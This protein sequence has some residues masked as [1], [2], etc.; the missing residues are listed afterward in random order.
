M[1]RYYSGDIEGKFMFGVQKSNSADRFGF[2]G[3]EPQHLEYYFMDDD[4][5]QVEAEILNIE[6]S[7]G[8]KLEVLKD[9]FENYDIYDDDLLREKNIIEHDLS[10]YADLLLGIKIRDCINRTTECS[11]TAEL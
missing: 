9:L 2:K 11:F 10:E 8:D 3:Q 4:L 5:E 7:L 6:T 1:G